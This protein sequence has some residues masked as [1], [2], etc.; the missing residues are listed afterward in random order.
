MTARSPASPNAVSLGPDHIY[1]ARPL[2]SHIWMLVIT[3]LALAFSLFVGFAFASSALPWTELAGLHL[4]SAAV[5]ALLCY[6]RG[7]KGYFVRE[8]C[9]LAFGYLLCGFLGAAGSL[10]LV[11]VSILT[12]TDNWRFRDWYMALFPADHVSTAE[13]LY[14]QLLSGSRTVGPE[15]SV[16]VYTDL[17]QEA[18]TDEKLAIVTLVARYFRPDFANVIIMAMN[19]ADPTVRVLAASAKAR[20]EN[21]F[22]A[23]VLKIQETIRKSPDNFDAKMALATL[24]DD[25]AFTGLLDREREVENRKMALETYEQCLRERPDDATPPYRIGRILNRQRDFTGAAS[26]FEIALE[27]SSNKQAIA[28]WLIEANY[29]A[30]NYDRVHEL[31]ARHFPETTAAKNPVV[32]PFRLDSMAMWQ[33]GSTE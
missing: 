28:S 27:R 14:S 5:I 29:N 26:M 1:T 21:R 33:K 23:N 19:D 20:I 30:K 15:H 11:I 22:L 4:A 13:D 32:S 31:I 9:V 8:Y 10:L 18:E 12:R 3:F 7:V 25:Y 24:Y 16:T 6:W 2:S 17:M